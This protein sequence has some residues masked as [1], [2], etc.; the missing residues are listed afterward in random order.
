MARQVF[1]FAAGADRPQRRVGAPAIIGPRRR[2]L[3]FGE[4]ELSVHVDDDTGMTT[5]RAEVPLIGFADP[6]P[7]SL[8]PSQVRVINPILTQVALGYTNSEFV[9]G[10]LFPK[11]PINIRGGQVLQ[12]G[13][14][15]F[16]TYNLKRAPGGTTEE[17]SFG[18]FGD[19]FALL[20]DAVDVKVPREYQQDAAVMPGIDIGAR[21]VRKGMAVIYK[22]LEIDQ[23][24]LALA[25]ANYPAGNQVALSGTAQWSNAS[26][27][28]VGGVLG[29]KE[30]VRTQ[31]GRYP[32]V[33][34]N[35]A[36]AW[37]SLRN[38][39]VVKQRYQYTTPDAITEQMI[40]KLLELD[41]VVVGKAVTAT[42][43]AVM[44]DIWGDNAVLAYVPQQL[45]AM[46][47]P[48]YG[49]T[50]TYEGTPYVEQPYWDAKR[51]AWIY[52]V[53]MDRLP[54]VTGIASGYLIQNPS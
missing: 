49:Y 22:S 21:A 2:P 41:K 48:S 46:E 29:Y 31:I 7:L 35:S 43:A 53:V 40:A 33:L 45:S 42:D 11:V 6:T 8:S 24:A 36:S 51:K 9:G 14:E 1:R 38:N 50:Y 27:D 10:A 37:L 47:E 26:S 15:D 25:T 18:Y 23:A 5:R 34:L 19:P 12:F 39:P 52:G 3:E 44:S 30:T 20:Q 4:P 28:P 17:I 16:K 54:V 32:N 13:F